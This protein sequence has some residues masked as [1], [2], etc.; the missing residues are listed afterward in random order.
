MDEVAILREIAALT[1]ILELV[2]QHILDVSSVEPWIIV[3]H[4]AN[5]DI[6]EGKVKVTTDTTFIGHP[7]IEEHMTAGDRVT[8]IHRLS[9]EATN[10]TGIMMIE[11]TETIMSKCFLNQAGGNLH[12]PKGTTVGIA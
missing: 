6:L 1:E 2:D 4:S 12:M 10:I 8:I 3:L 9:Q 7:N 11:D 5:N